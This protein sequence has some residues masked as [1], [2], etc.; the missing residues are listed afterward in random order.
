[1][2]RISYV[3]LLGDRVSEQIEEY[4]QWPSEPDHSARSSV[5]WETPWLAHWSPIPAAFPGAIREQ[6]CPG[7]CRGEERRAPFP[8]VQ[9]DEGQGGRPRRHREE[10]KEDEGRRGS[11]HRDSFTG[12]GRAG[13]RRGEARG[14][15]VPLADLARS[16]PL[17]SKKKTKAT[18]GTFFPLLIDD[19]NKILIIYGR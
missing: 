8:T 12:R 7:C 17:T 10:G 3:E 1:M 2:S 16:P 4:R 6:S 19:T 11:M 9:D 5:N 13:R 14:G 18:A 15:R